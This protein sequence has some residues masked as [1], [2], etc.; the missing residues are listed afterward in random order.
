ML[1]QNSLLKSGGNELDKYLQGMNRVEVKITIGIFINTISKIKVV[2]KRWT[3][4]GIAFCQHL[5][6]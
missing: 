5:K 2:L 1:S 3:F 4:L 6:S